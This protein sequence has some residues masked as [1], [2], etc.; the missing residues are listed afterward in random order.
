MLSC[1]FYLVHIYNLHLLTCWSSPSV[2]S[3]SSHL[4]IQDCWETQLRL[5]R[6]DFPK[7][8]WWTTLR[9]K[10]K[11]QPKK[12][13]IFPYVHFHDSTFFV[14]SIDMD[15]WEKKQPNIPKKHMIIVPQHHQ[16]DIKYQHVFSQQT[17]TTK[18]AIKNPSTRIENYG[19]FCVL[20]LHALI[21]ESD[22]ELRQ[23]L[24][25]EPGKGTAGVFASLP[26]NKK[27][28]TPVN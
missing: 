6:Q 24:G 16:M 8:R 3:Y 2:L 17:N 4:P 22:V 26:T 13:T 23:Q 1:Y 15:E 19:D 9:P 7:N 25:G 18:P 14:L 10:A 21:R 12:Y 5:N 28:Y 11:F 20:P 27:Q